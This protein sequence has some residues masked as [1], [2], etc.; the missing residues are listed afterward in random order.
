MNL[1]EL[2]QQLTRL[3]A[4]WGGDVPVKMPVNIGDHKDTDDVSGA[5]LKAVG[6]SRFVLIQGV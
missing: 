2:I 5:T 3:R 4:A 1:D 6:Q